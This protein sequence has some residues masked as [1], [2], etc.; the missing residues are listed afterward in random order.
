MEV[1]GLFWDEPTQKPL[2]S[3]TL[4]AAWQIWKLFY[5]H[6]SL[7]QTVPIPYN[8]PMKGTVMLWCTFSDTSSVYLGSH[9]FQIDLPR[10]P[11]L[12]WAFPCDSQEAVQDC[13]AP[14]PQSQWAST[15]HVTPVGSNK[16]HG[17]FWE[18]RK[19][20]S[21]LLSTVWIKYQVKM[22]WVAAA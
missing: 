14:S 10:W 7:F 20:T 16:M 1:K 11:N 9:G 19:C 22:Q 15:V 3:F 6:Y 21:R 8:A 18:P 12:R 13:K 4:W 5:M 2:G 17:C